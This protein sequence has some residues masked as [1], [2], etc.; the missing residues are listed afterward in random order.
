VTGESQARLVEIRHDEHRRI[1]AVAP[2]LQQASQW[3]S[4]KLAAV[5]PHHL[6]IPQLATDGALDLLPMQLTQGQHGYAHCATSR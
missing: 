4:P 5:D 1:D 6:R 2:Q 3:R